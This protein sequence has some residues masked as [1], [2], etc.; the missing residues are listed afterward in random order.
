MKII[1][2]VEKRSQ[3]Y[4]RKYK[5]ASIFKI[6]T[7][8]LISSSLL[9]AKAIPELASKYNDILKSQRQISR[10]IFGFDTGIRKVLKKADITKILIKVFKLVHNNREIKCIYSNNALTVYSNN[11]SIPTSIQKAVNCTKYSVR[12]A[13]IAYNSNEILL[14]RSNY[15]YRIYI[16]LKPVTRN[17]QEKLRNFI[18]TYKESINV[19]EQ[20]NYWAIKCVRLYTARGFFD[21]NSDLLLF[22]KLSIPELKSK[23]YKIVSDADR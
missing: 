10:T 23:Q 15:K 5:Y 12:E 8:H 11:L 18:Q 7:I 2:K 4:Y 20:L 17:V 13:Q 21:S 3:L 9:T 6:P 16:N 1:P 14:K 22:L 19:S